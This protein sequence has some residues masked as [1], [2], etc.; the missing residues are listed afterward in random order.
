[1]EKTFISLEKN[2]PKISKGQYVFFTT[3]EKGNLIG[4]EIK[5]VSSDGEKISVE[6]KSAGKKITLSGEVEVLFEN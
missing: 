2:L 1:M 5:E 3:T 6:I 4:G